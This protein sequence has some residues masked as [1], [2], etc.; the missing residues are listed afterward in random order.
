MD[1]LILILKAIPTAM[2]LMVKVAHTAMIL[3][4]M[5]LM[6]RVKT[7]TKTVTHIPITT[8]TLTTMIFNDFISLIR[9]VKLLYKN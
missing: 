9:S 1:S 2:I 8:V 7:L 5:T 3:M 6:I 4:A